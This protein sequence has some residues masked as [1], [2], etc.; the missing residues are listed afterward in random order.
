MNIL[1]L[2][3]VENINKQSKIGTIYF[4]QR[5]L[6]TLEVNYIYFLNI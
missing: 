5:C 2:I 4:K 6:L 3:Y 1:G